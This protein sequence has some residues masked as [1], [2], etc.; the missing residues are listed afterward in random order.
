[1]KLHKEAFPTLFFATIIFILFNVAMWRLL[2]DYPSIY[3]LIFFITFII[4]TL[5][6]FFFRVPS[7]VKAIDTNK[8]ISPAHGKIVEIIDEE[9]T[10]FFKDKRKRVS[11]FMSPLNIHCN[12]SPVYGQVKSMDY[13]PG[14]YLFAFHPKSSQLNEHT[15]TVIENEHLAIGVKQIAGFIARRIVPYFRVGQT[16]NQNDELGFIKF[17]SRVDLYLPTDTK[18]AV[19]EGDRVLG[20]VTVI[21]ELN[22]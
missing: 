22:K 4:L 9:E 21:S 5:T 10:I 14:K 3:N 2:V 1:M 7:T 8:I 12:Y 11:I 19:K 20:G 13:F 16:V 17:G 6:F 18:L 15:F